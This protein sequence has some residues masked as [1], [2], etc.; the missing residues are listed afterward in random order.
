[1]PPVVREHK[2]VILVTG[3]Y[4]DLCKVPI[5]AMQRL[6][7]SWLVPP[8]C[9]SSVRELPVGAQLLRQTPLRSCGG[10]INEQQTNEQH[11]DEQQME[12]EQQHTGGVFEQAWGVPFC[13]EEFM[14]EAVSR[15]HPKLFS[16]LVPQIL[17]DAIHNN[18][19][20]E[21]LQKLPAERAKW[22]AKWTARAKQ[23]TQK[24]AEL[25]S[26]LP[27]HAACILE[28]KRLTLFKEI[29]ED[30]GYPD[31]GAYDEL[32]NGTELVGEVK[33][34]GI[35]EKAFR[36][37]EITTE[38]LKKSGR[39]SRLLNFYRCSSSGDVEVDEVVYRKTLEEV[40]LGWALGPIELSDLPQD[41]VVSRRFG[42]KQPSK[43]R[44]IDDLSSS[45]VNQT[46]Q[47][48]ESPKP[49]SVDFIA[50]MLLEVLKF[51]KGVHIFGRS[52]DLKS[53]YK[54]LAIAAES[55]T[56]AFVAVY[57][58]KLGKAELF[59]LLAAPFG[60]REVCILF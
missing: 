15:G 46:V 35:F 26:T 47:T 14:A 12:T 8:N 7:T 30:V 31:L 44:L 33:P 37:A 54:Q 1:M 38:Q 17:Q 2:Q 59:Q 48:A 45:K 28:P 23:L 42:L 36:P 60:Q 51:N 22:F 57:N 49:H 21:S 25:K 9:K 34:F 5:L 55:L 10:R 56:F 58:P 6:K 52:F 24:D 13:P 40:E 20:S 43:I 27:H 29:L 16:R 39:A 11:T 18:F 19:C 41:A 3:P 32:V 4:I 50:A 53:A